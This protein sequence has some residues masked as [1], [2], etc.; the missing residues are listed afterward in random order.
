MLPVRYRLG[1]PGAKN[2]EYLTCLKIWWGGLHFARLQ[3]KKHAHMRA[4]A[5]LGT[6]FMMERWLSVDCIWHFVLCHFSYK[7]ALHSGEISCECLSLIWDLAQSRFSSTILKT[8]CNWRNISM[9][10]YCWVGVNDTIKK[11]WCLIG[12]PRVLN[13]PFDDRT[14][15]CSVH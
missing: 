8:C 1:R 6:E 15:S 2:I 9:S 14:T 7:I 13:I 12:Q 5:T 10:F 3:V 4:L 11:T